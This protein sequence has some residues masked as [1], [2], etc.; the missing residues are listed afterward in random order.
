MI[1]KVLTHMFKNSNKN[2]QRKTV[3]IN[4]DTIRL[5]PNPTGLRQEFFRQSSDI[6]SCT[7]RNRAYSYGAEAQN[8]A[9]DNSKL[10]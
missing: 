4:E 5:P 3:C 1:L 6:I 2:H 8:I 9:G 10:Q 7:R